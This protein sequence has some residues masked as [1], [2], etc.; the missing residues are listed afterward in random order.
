MEG[1]LQP[2]SPRCRP[3][4]LSMCSTV[5]K[6]RGT[7][8]PVQCAGIFLFP[9]P[10]GRPWPCARTDPWFRS[11]TLLVLRHGGGYWSAGIRAVSQYDSSSAPPP[12]RPDSPATPPRTDLPDPHDPLSR[13]GPVVC[14]SDGCRADVWRCNAGMQRLVLLHPNV[15]QQRNKTRTGARQGGASSGG[16]GGGGT[17]FSYDMCAQKS[18]RNQVWWLLW[19]WSAT[20]RCM[21]TVI[22]H[23]STLP[24]GIFASRFL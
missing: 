1:A 18:V 24:T 20:C 8:P 14:G 16:G 23:V 21:A 19:R 11:K 9:T 3:V 17:R 12:P 4:H 15:V 6:G 7:H 2:S 10:R 13:N 5:R 22:A